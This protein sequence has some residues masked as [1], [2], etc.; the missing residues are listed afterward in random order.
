VS[1]TLIVGVALLLVATVGVGCGSGKP[2]PTTLALSWTLPDGGHAPTV[3]L[4]IPKT[5]D[6]RAQFARGARV[7]V[8]EG[9]LACH[10][11]AGNGNDGPGPE[12]T[13]LGTKLTAAQL[14]HTLRTPVSPM[15]SYARLPARQFDDLVHF[16]TQLR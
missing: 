1:K 14:A 10:K 9:C 4:A 7:A 3:H 12:L 15:P 6:D 5:V 16:L 8:D 2:Q 11:I 13:K